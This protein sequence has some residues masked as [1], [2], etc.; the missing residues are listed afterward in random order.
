MTQGGGAAWTGGERD[1]LTGV[2][3]SGM[4]DIPP[5]SSGGR[6]PAPRYA[7][8]RCLWER[9]SAEEQQVHSVGT[10][11]GGAVGRVE[12]QPRAALSPGTISDSHQMRS[13][14]HSTLTPPPHSHT[15][16]TCSKWFKQRPEEGF[17]ARYSDS[18]FIPVGGGKVRRED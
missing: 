5:G 6:P 8:G 1:S 4:P 17:R 12:P 2:L 15:F 16:E 14:P 10:C 11:R 18:Y 13:S 3:C 9:R 7:T